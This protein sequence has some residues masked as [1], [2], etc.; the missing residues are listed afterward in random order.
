MRRAAA[1]TS[2]VEASRRA[3]VTTSTGTSASAGARMRWAGR[4]S[5]SAK[6]VRSDLVPGD[7]VAERGA[8]RVD[9][10]GAAAAASASGM[11]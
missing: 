10:E 7:D 4:P 2:V 1:T 5:A 3:A 11:L 9:V 6:T 8:Q